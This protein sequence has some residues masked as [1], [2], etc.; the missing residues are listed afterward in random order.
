[1]HSL[2]SFTAVAFEDR[3]APTG[4]NDFAEG[5][6]QSRLSEEGCRLP[7][8]PRSHQHY[9]STRQARQPGPAPEQAAWEARASAFSYGG[10]DEPRVLPSDT[11]SSERWPSEWRPVVAVRDREHTRA[12]EMELA[13]RRRVGEQRQYMHSARPEDGCWVST[14]ALREQAQHNPIDRAPVPQRAVISHSAPCADVRAAGRAAPARDFRSRSEAFATGFYPPPGH[15]HSRSLSF[16]HDRPVQ[17]VYD[18]YDENHGRVAAGGAGNSF[19]HP[20]ASP[21]PGGA[22]GV[23]QGY[24][25]GGRMERGDGS[26]PLA[27]MAKRKKRGNLPPEAKKKMMAWFKTHLHHPYPDEE[28]KKKWIAETG[29]S[30]GQYPP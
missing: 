13:R 4:R 16:L 28:T 18:A 26:G 15:G 22:Y 9:Y 3:S 25:V 10:S 19:A 24:H 5:A 1:M 21:Y 12:E 2:D 29:L 27:E 7:N 23:P 17:W 20:M 11:A 14:L 8:S 6:D 30:P